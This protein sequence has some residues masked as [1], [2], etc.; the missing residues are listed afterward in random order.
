M[1]KW[2]IRIL[3]SHTNTVI[4]ACSQSVTIVNTIID[5]WIETPSHPGNP[6]EGGLIMVLLLLLLLLPGVHVLLL[7]Y[8][9]RKS[10]RVLWDLL[11]LCLLW[12]DEVPTL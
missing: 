9:P 3:W 1:E 6:S 5:I 4:I 7:P 12:W 2:I 10:Q 8:T 11:L